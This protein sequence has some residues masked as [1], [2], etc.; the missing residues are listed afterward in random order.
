MVQKEMEVW[1]TDKEADSKMYIDSCQ[2][3]R[4]HPRW[5]LTA[6]H[7]VYPSCN[8][9]LPCTVQITLASAELRQT[10][11]IKHS[12]TAKNVFIYEGFFP[13]QNRISSM[14]VA[15]VKFDPMTATY[16]YEEWNDQQNQFVPI[17]KKEFG[18]KLLNSPVTRAQLNAQM[19]RRFV[20]VARSH[21][22][23]FLQPIIVPLMKNGNLSYLISPTRSIFYVE[24]LRHF[25]SPSFGVDH[26]NSGGGVFTAQGDLVGLVSAVGGPRGRSG[27]A[28]AFRNE[29]G[30]LVL[31]LPNADAYFLFTGFNNAT[32]NFINRNIQGGVTT[33]EAENG[34]VKPTAKKF[35]AII[36]AIDKASVVV[37]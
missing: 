27:G 13:G 15:L 34:F 14:D 6:A 12:T 36:K 3:V 25:I 30:E 1:R 29:E 4:I 2:A 10:V 22:S 35:N 31:T 11:R 19:V 5:F 20:S 32:M 7:C 21:N 37:E 16:A 8:G 9:S 24:E 23:R 17:T 18:D 26:G 28:V 33:I